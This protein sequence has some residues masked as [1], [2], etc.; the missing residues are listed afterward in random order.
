MGKNPVCVLAQFKTTKALYHACERVRDEGYVKFDAHSPFP[1]HGLDRA[2]GLKPSKVPWIVL[3]LGLLGAAGGMGMQLWMN[4]VDYPMIFSAKPYFSWQAYVP[5]T[6]ELGVLFG[7]AG[8][9]FGMLGLNQLPRLNHPVFNSKAFSTHAADDGFFLSI[10]TKDANY[11]EV[12][13]SKLLEGLGALQ[14]EHLKE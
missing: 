13:T 6:F 3:I 14:V 10:E 8:A 9:V 4:G 5:I 2:M 1:I 12:R 7:S 11:D